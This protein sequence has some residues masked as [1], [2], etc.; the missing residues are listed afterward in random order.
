MSDTLSLS[1]HI[2]AK[3]ETV[4]QFLSDPELFKQW[5]GPGAILR[6][7]GI[8]VR[9]PTGETA[10]GTLRESVANERIVFGWGY[11]GDAHGLAPDST[12]V[13]IRLSATPTGTLVTL[14]HTGL[15][16]ARQADHAKGWNHYLGQLAAAAANRGYALALPAAVENYIKAWNETGASLRAGHL[17]ACWEEDGI[18]RDSMGQADSR[19]A[20]LH[21]IGNAQKFVPGFLLELAS[22][23]EQCHGYYR[24]SWRILTP[25]GSV[26]GR[27]TNFGQLSSAGRFLSAIG[28]WDKA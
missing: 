20:L 28:F 23:P 14:E 4:F 3:P 8:A 5:M 7:D 17:E 16:A 26:M 9:Y 2:H 18:F 6:P 25:D 11:E 10:K 13:T 12:I 22:A 15:D 27:G 1:I 19:T 24:F 21:Y